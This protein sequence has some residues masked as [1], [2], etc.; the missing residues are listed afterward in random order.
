MVDSIRHEEGRRYFRPVHDLY[1]ALRRQRV[2]KPLP[3]DLIS[4][5]LF[6]PLIHL[7]KLNMVGDIILD[8]DA[9][10]QSFQASW[11]AVRMTT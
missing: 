4:A 1:E 7:M 5:H 6:F 3:D 10:E 9:L 11:D 8:G 2:L